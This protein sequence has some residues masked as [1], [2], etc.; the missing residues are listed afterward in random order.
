MTPRTETAAD[1]PPFPESQTLT[2]SSLRARLSKKVKGNNY[3]TPQEM[4]E[5]SET[6]LS[7]GVIYPRAKIWS[8]LQRLP[9][10]HI[11]V[12]EYGIYGV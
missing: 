9:G 5:L 8:I 10:N 6:L 11:A 4:D 2:R 7:V 3:L 12:S 1:L